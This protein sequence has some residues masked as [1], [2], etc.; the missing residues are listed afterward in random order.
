MK[1]KGIILVEPKN[2]VNV[3]TIARTMAA[4]GIEKLIIVSSKE[5]FEEIF[6]KARK[7]SMGGVHILK[8]AEIY[9]SLKDVNGK[10]IGTI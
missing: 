3:G 8:N 7:V 6:E 2:P 4:F 10:K 9:S 1:V 5:R